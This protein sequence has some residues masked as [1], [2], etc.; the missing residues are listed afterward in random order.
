MRDGGEEGE[1]RD[2]DDNDYEDDDYAIF[3]ITNSRPMIF[4]FG[5]IHPCLIIQL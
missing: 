1:R 2:D 3:S 5:Q 4:Y